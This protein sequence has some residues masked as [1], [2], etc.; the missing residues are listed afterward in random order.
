MKAG[1]MVVWMV[2]LKAASMV[3]MMVELLDGQMADPTVG[4]TAD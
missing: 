2:G 3:E 4:K 1:R